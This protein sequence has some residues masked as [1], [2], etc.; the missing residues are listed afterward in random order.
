MSEDLNTESNFKF[1]AFSK[2]GIELLQKLTTKQTT[3]TK[4]INKKSSE[5]T[6][7]DINILFY[8]L[9]NLTYENTS[10]IPPQKEI[11]IELNL[12]LTKCLGHVEK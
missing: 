9:N 6:S 11:C 1:I 5:L 2:Q 3:S 12:F 8:I 4:K 7:A 10:T